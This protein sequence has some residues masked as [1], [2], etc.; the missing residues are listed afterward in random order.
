MSVIN[1]FGPCWGFTLYS[2]WNKRAEIWFIPANYTIVEH[3]HPSENVELCY[4]FGRTKFLRRDLYTG[5][6]KEATMTWRNW[7][8]CFS[9]KHH[10]S[11]WFSTSNWPLIFINF[12][13]FLPGYKP[14]SAS[15]DFTVT[16]NYDN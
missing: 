2:F 7:L 13:T 14:V 10:H 15:V 9:V 11:H 12:Q 8:T 16:A 3:S 5:K 1:R 4:I 6:I